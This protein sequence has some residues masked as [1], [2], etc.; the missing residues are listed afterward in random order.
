MSRRPRIGDVIH[1]DLTEENGKIKAVN[2]IIEGVEPFSE[3]ANCNTLMTVV[4]TA[5]I[6]SALTAIIMTAVL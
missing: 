5:I 6:S 1:Y 4:V 3:G 2:A